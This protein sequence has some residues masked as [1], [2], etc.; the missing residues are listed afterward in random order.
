MF[1]FSV[2]TTVCSKNLY[3]VKDF[4]DHLN[5]LSHF[6]TKPYA[7]K[8]IPLSSVLHDQP[9]TKQCLDEETF[10]DFLTRFDAEEVEWFLNKPIDNNN[11]N[12]CVHEAVLSQHVHTD[13]LA[14][15][16]K[17]GGNYT[18]VATQFIFCHI[19]TFIGSPNVKGFAGK[20]SVLCCNYVHIII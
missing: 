8:P 2:D 20:V 7:V 14:T 4:Y 9:L 16:L 13:K 11:G 17:H 15:I 18:L 10:H 19:N 6:M 3:F 12:T 5:T 1:S